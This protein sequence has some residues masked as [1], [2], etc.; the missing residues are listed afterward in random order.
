MT[1]RST[2]C[3]LA[4]IA[5]SVV[6]GCTSNDARFGVHAGADTPS[7]TRTLTYEVPSATVFYDPDPFL[8]ER[9]V[10]EFSRSRDADGNPAMAMTLTDEGTE[11]MREWSGQ[12]IENYAV[13]TLDGEVLSAPRVMSQ[14]SRSIQ[15]TTGSNGDAG[16]IDDLEAALE[17]AGA[18]RP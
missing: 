15:V 6:S 13:M 3:T 4:L 17:R 11:I 10:A 7:E 2:V 18:E 8:T 16:W 1:I 14:L 5:G 9:H 12:N